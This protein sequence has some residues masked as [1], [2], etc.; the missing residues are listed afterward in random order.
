MSIRQ[1]AILLR[2]EDLLSIQN[3]LFEAKKDELIARQIVSMNTNHPPYASE[4]GYDWYDREGSAIILAAGGSAKDIPFVGEKGGRETMKVYTIATGVRYTKAERQAVQA[5][6][7]LGKGPTV[8]LDTLRVSNARRFVSEKENEIFFTGNE[9]YGIPGVLNKS[10]IVVESVADGAAGSGAAKKLWANKTPKEILKDLLTAKDSVEKAGFFQA[11]I[12]ILTPSAYN[13]LLQPYSDQSPMT[14][15]SWLQSQ[16]MTF[17]KIVKSRSLL[18]NY[19]GFSTVDAFLVLD[20]NPEV[21]ELAV[22]EDLLIGEPVYDILGT[23]EQAVTERVA[24]AIIRHPSAIY[25]GKGI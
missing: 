11:K 22:T 7:A 20:N 17:D 14:V 3:I 5:K 16:G 6:A 23:S 8:Q 21:I 24:G 19:N 18:K 1:D 25:V 13:K 2:K 9:K 15:L 12:L 10:G 4:I